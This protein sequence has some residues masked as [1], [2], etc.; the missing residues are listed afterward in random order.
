M[1][2]KRDRELIGLQKRGQH[3]SE[4]KWLP[5]VVANTQTSKYQEK[6]LCIYEVEETSLAACETEENAEYYW[7]PIEG[8]NKD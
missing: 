2:R 8:K 7:I 3:K 4:A 6:F 5:V 1:H